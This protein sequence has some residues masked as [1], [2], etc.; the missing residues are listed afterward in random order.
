MLTVRT[1]EAEELKA[2]ELGA[3]DYVA[4]PFSPP[5]LMQRIRRALRS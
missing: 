2:F 4:K 3:F 5:V 1:T